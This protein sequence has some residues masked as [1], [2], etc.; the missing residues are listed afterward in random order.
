M[1]KILTL[2]GL[3]IVILAIYLYMGFYNISASKPHMK[4][5]EETFEGIMENSIKH[6]T[7]DIIKP[8]ISE[9]EVLSEG[10]EHYNAM[11]VDC[12][13]APGNS[14]PEFREGLYPKPPLFAKGIDDEIGTE[15]IFWVTKNGIKMTGMPGF[16]K[17]HTDD[18][19]WAI[20]GFVE[21]LPNM[22]EATYNEL[23]L[24]NKGHHHDEDMGEGNT[25]N[26]EVMKKADGMEG[27][28]G[29]M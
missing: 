11:C 29:N 23:K 12:H 25:S 3:I 1:N 26:T 18:E 27:E 10:F 2:I 4:L 14:E 9:D 28:S 6:H 21:K 22:S 7:K 8:A 17:T 20:A 24:K 15:Q 5:I 16:G 13:G 19:I